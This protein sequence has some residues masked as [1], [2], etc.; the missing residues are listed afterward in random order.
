MASKSVPRDIETISHFSY[1]SQQAWEMSARHQ[2]QFEQL[3]A[4]LRAIRE[5]LGGRGNAANLAA[6]GRTLADQWAIDARLDCDHVRDRRRDI[7]EQAAGR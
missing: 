3:R 2:D 6:A 1:L 4:I 5:E 7:E